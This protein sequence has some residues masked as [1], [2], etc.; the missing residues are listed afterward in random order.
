MWREVRCLPEAWLALQDVLHDLV[1]VFSRRLFRVGVERVGHL[2]AEFL[3]LFS[4]RWPNKSMTKSL[5]D[6]IIDYE[7]TWNTVS[8]GVFFN[9]FRK[10]LRRNRRT[11]T[12]QIFTGFFRDV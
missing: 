6:R 4:R 7:L 2:I 12:F 10:S 3:R 1:S 9:N 11:I 8:I 5:S